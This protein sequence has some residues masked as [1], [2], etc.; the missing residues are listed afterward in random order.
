MSSDTSL[1]GKRK[2]IYD[3]DD[4]RTA[5]KFKR[6][7]NL[8]NANLSLPR[9]NK[10]LKYTSEL[11]DIKVPE[12]DTSNID[13][14]GMIG[15]INYFQT[16]IQTTILYPWNRIIN[17]NKLIKWKSSLSINKQLQY[18]LLIASFIANI[19]NS[20]YANPDCTRNEY[21]IENYIPRGTQNSIFTGKIQYPTVKHKLIYNSDNN[22]GIPI[23]VKTMED[24]H[25]NNNHKEQI[26]HEAA[27]GVALNSIGDKTPNF[28]YFY[29]LLPCD[30]QINTNNI[31]ESNIC[32]DIEYPGYAVYEYIE[33][34]SLFDVLN[35]LTS[36]DVINILC[37]ILL[38]LAIASKEI[39]FTHYNLT[40][41]NIIVVDLNRE[42]DIMYEFDGSI[43][44]LR[45]TRYL[46]KIINYHTAYALYQDTHIVKNMTGF[47]QYGYRAGPNHQYDIIMLMKELYHVTISIS[48]EDE[49]KKILLESINHLYENDIQISDI[50]SI[51][52]TYLTPIYE[53]NM[54]TYSAISV[55]DYLVSVYDLRIEYEENKVMN[56]K[57][58][59]P[60]ETLFEQIKTKL[61]RICIESK[62]DEMNNTKRTLLNSLINPIDSTISN[63]Y[64]DKTLINSYRDYTKEYVNELIENYNDII[65][66]YTNKFYPQT[67]Q[68]FYGD[69]IPISIEENIMASKYKINKV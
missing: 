8:Y 15:I 14:Y 12:F 56:E 57:L 68:Y 62:K 2:R 59:I 61:K 22:L 7:I 6:E 69:Y 30:L 51:Y 66:K 1:L 65:D 5:K 48:G 25:I 54:Y 40:L 33:G 58:E 11:L 63:K 21:R 50:N 67:N 28:M 47:E 31:K 10:H 29:G 43:F 49:L 20:L 19:R 3:E 18:N 32:H 13:Y 41:N 64:D 9:N 52:Y 34:K 60:Y 36:I 44:K 4:V 55:F 37:Q 38:S 17:F 27:I 53:Q 45:Q 35:D 46:A 16:L 39:S 42:Q 24:Y 26:I 23:T